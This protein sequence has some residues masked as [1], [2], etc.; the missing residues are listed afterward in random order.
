LKPEFFSLFDI[1]IA[2][3]WLVLILSLLW[4]IRLHHT[5]EEHYKLFYPAMLFK[6]G[7]GLLFAITYTM[8]LEGGGDTLAYWEGAV[9]LNN[10][11]W[12]RPSAYFSEIFQTPSAQTMTNNFNPRTG[13]PPSWIY[14][15]PESFFICKI[16]S[17]FTFFTFNSYVSM[18]LICAAIAGLSAWKLYELVKDF[19][20]C[21]PWILATSTLFLPT[22]AFWC[23]GISKDTFILAAFQIFLF[24]AFSILIKKRSF[25]FEAVFMLLLTSFILYRIRDFMIIAIGAPFLFVLLSRMIRRRSDNPMFLWIARGVS[26]V[27]LIVS[28]LTYFQSL[29]DS[30]SKTNAYLE[31]VI[32]IQQDFNQN[33]LYTG[34][35]Y[36]LGITEYTPSG[37][38][39]AAPISIITAFYRPFIWEA[40][41][42]FLI[43]SGLE[44]I[45][46]LCLTFG[47]FFRSGNIFKHFAF[48]RKQEFLVFAILFSLLLGFFVGFTSGL[49]NVLVRFKAPYMVLIVIFFAAKQSQQKH[50][51][52]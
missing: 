19:D 15:E 21:K 22:V 51:T 12:D 52:D 41:S 50:L 23:S 30:S 11:F 39:K 31:E 24:Y 37:M 5:E 3:G 18:T 16:L 7:F 27:I 47:F 36:D 6:I 17:I 14:N 48:I 40:N 1:S 38:I 25:N 10:L 2:F 9:D 26:T 13:Y 44:G 29:D 28:T 33:K 35:R 46:L 32:V 42:A 45:L 8:I 4:V 49:F 34:Y 43:V 20:F